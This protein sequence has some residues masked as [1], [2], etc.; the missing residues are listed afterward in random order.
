[1]GFAID[2]LDRKVRQS[3]GGYPDD[4]HTVITAAYAKGAKDFGWDI[5]KQCH[6]KVWHVSEPVRS[7][8]NIRA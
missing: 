2:I 4:A 5:D 1:V 6:P 8:N 7:E 3:A